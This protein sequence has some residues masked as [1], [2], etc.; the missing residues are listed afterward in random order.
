MFGEYN[1]V[2]ASS[3]PPLHEQT[4]IFSQLENEYM[5][6]FEDNDYYYNDAP[7]ITIL[8]HGLGGS[9]SHWSN[10]TIDPLKF[11]INTSSIIYK[12]FEKTNGNIDLYRAIIEPYYEESYK[13]FKYSYSNY[14][15]GNM[16]ATT[17]KDI[18]DSC[19]KHIVIVY[20][21][22]IS[23]VNNDLNLS[24]ETAYNEFHCF[25]DSISFKYK[26]LT[27][28]LPKL[29]LIGHS[30]GGIIN[31]MYAVD[32]P[33]NVHTLISI[34]TPYNGSSI[35]DIEAFLDILNMDGIGTESILNSNENI[36][37]RNRWN[38]INKND[39]NINAITY[40]GISTINYFHTLLNEI[41]T[42]EFYQSK[43]EIETIEN[44][45][46]IISLLITG[47]DLI[48]NKVKF[49]LSL[50]NG[51]LF[52]QDSVFGESIY[53]SIGADYE[54]INNLINLVQQVNGQTVL[55]ADLFV[56][57]N[58]QLGAGFDDGGSYNG[59]K[60]FVKVFDHNDFSMN[61]ADPSSPGIVHNLETMNPVIVNSIVN[62]L[63]L[64]VQEN[65]IYHFT[66]FDNINITIDEARLFYFTPS[67]TGTAD[68][69]AANSI[70]NVYEIDRI[71]NV[72]KK[73]FP[74]GVSDFRN[75]YEVVFSKNTKYMFS[76]SPPWN[77]ST[78]VRF[79]NT[80][81]LTF[82]N[83]VSIDLTPK[84][85]RVYSFKATESGYYCFSIDNPN[86]KITTNQDGKFLSDNKVCIYL[87]KNEELIMY[88]ENLTNT[89]QNIIIDN[90]ISLLEKSNYNLEYEVLDNLSIYRFIN[91]TGF[92][93]N[94]EI[95][96]S[97]CYGNIY[98]YNI[99]GELISTSLVNTNSNITDFYLD[100][101]EI[102]FVIFENCLDTVFEAYNLE[103]DVYWCINDEIVDDV[104]TL[105]RGESY[106]I[107]LCYDVNDEKKEYE[108]YIEVMNSNNFSYNRSSN[109]LDIFEN[110]LI[111]YAITL[112]PSDY[113]GRNLYI[114]IE[115]SDND[116]FFNVYNR[117][118][119]SFQWES[120][121]NYDSIYIE[122]NNGEITSFTMKSNNTNIPLDEYI[123]PET[124]GKITVEVKTITI[125]NCTFSI[126]KT[127]EVD[128]LYSYGEGTLL[129]P[130]AISSYRHLNNIRYCPNKCFKITS[131]IDMSNKQWEP[132]D[133]FDGYIDGYSSK[134][135]NM[136]LEYTGSEYFGFINHLGRN[137]KIENIIFSNCLV[138]G[139]ITEASAV[140]CIGLIVGFCDGV[141]EDCHINTSDINITIDKSFV[142][143]IAGYT[144]QNA[145]VSLC[146]ASNSNI[147]S[148]GDT[149]A[150][151]GHNYGNIHHCYTN[152]INLTYQRKTTNRSIGIVVGINHGN[153]N[154]VEAKGII[155]WNSNNLFDS[156]ISPCIGYVLGYNST[157]GTY[158]NLMSEVE[159]NIFCNSL[160]N[161][162]S[163]C[164]AFENGK[165]GYVQTA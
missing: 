156:N 91:N 24:N 120:D 72:K 94:F 42:N 123:L 6:G 69:I 61:R 97:N 58:S 105:P 41:E 28:K 35:G 3:A 55:L 27:G 95:E 142:G 103:N 145:Y 73:V 121:L 20:D 148:S 62:T 88:F 37:L 164:F 8:T 40:G 26:S 9:A 36:E 100:N 141:I 85:S 151:V 90:Q 54:E 124:E 63:Y 116:I 79:K 64:G 44:Y 71:G 132:I 87:S 99:N 5:Y 144:T 130:Y 2:Y 143:F 80:Q 48:P 84:E 60:R 15:S 136:N 108:G 52:L 32:H 13:L 118:S 43:Y 159:A 160:L 133:R 30:R 125:N 46:E 86:V 161:Q 134:I 162:N 47:V 147:L 65:Q 11:K 115:P 89:I 78:F 51:L 98:V 129:S 127:Y 76:I 92:D 75:K 104:I 107:K 57:A 128:N 117:D 29:N 153:L 34:G 158:S 106:N 22:Y 140:K 59:F 68:I 23:D 33:Y 93:S 19:D 131:D 110:A 109:S 38:Q 146:T 138:S 157:T 135:T 96:A 122:V 50:I 12:L 56:D 152:N 21:R 74:N 53:D 66:E 4:R 154:Y 119:V 155:N 113:D 149:G 39:V 70:I 111:G 126:N 112:D 67:S 114:T 137:A 83:E 17:Q 150:I 49:N 102:C 10:D 7:T 82:E 45:Q 77:G 81:E 18:F 14:V 31:M 101:E 163:R 25:V 16:T 165:I 139:T 1:V